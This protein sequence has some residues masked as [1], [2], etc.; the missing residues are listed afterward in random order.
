MNNTWIIYVHVVPKEITNY[1]F[2]KYYIG[3]TS[4]TF[5][6]RCKN[7]N[8]YKQCTHFWNAIKKYG[9]DNIQHIILKD[10]LTEYEAKEMEKILINYFQS[11]NSTYGYNLTMGGDGTLGL[12][13]SVE[14]KNK[15]SKAK[16][17]K[18]YSPEVLNSFKLKRREKSKNV[19]QFDKLG[20]FVREFDSVAQ[21]SEITGYK[22][23]GIANC[24]NNESPTY[25]NY[26][27]KYKNDLTEIELYNLSIQPYKKK[28]N[29]DSLKK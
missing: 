8:G 22:A 15:I 2:D 18:K 1:G 21:A 26:M 25:K 5:E 23:K 9:W 27:W 4:Q 3:I 16:K 14:S 11:N 13:H 19:F 12:S 20:N 6:C 24:C 28:I 29:I 7:G 10:N 17:G